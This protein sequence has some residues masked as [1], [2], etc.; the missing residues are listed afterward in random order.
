MHWVDIAILAIIVLS[1]I[2]GFMRG[3]V[4]E[5]IA[6][7]V[8]ILA[9]WLAFS[10]AQTLEV[11]LQ[12]YIQ[13]KTFRIVAAFIAIL[14][15]TLIAGGLVN[16][17]LG[18]ILKHTGLSGMDRILGMGFGMIRG[19]FIVA[20]ILLAIKMTSLPHEQYSRESKLYSHFDPIVNWLY[21]LTPQFIKQVRLF[22]IKPGF[23]SQLSV[24]DGANDFE[25]SES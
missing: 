13:D 21:E 18:F 19:I 22:K 17:L 2:T 4:K 24:L 10:Y 16:S 3:F 12:K 11:W 15:A 8:W 5:L 6:L 1:V 9:L 25:L 14:L 7:S 20:L 23:E